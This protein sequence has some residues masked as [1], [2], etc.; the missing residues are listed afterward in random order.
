MA[1]KRKELPELHGVEVSGVA[2]EGKAIARVK[3]RETDETPI[4][5][6]IPYA[7][8]GDI[9]D[10]KIDK[11]KHSYAEAHITRI[12]EPSPIRMA[13]RCPSFGTCGGCKWQHIPYQEQLRH[14]HRIVADALERIAKVDLPEIRPT[15][16]S[17]NIW[18]YRNKM[19]YTFSNKKWR[20]W[21]DIR[22]GKE[23]AD[24]SNALGFHIPGAFDKVLHIDNCHL[25]DTKGDEIRNFIYDFA[26]SHGYSFYNIKENHGLLR[27]LMLRIASTG[28]IMVCLT[29]GEDD[30]ERIAEI[31]TAIKE[32]FPEITSLLYVVNRKL[33]DSIADQEVI[34]FSGPEYI[35]EEMEGLRFRINAK[36]FYQTNSLQAYELYK[37]AR[38]FAGLDPK[39][40]NDGKKPLVYDLYTGTG[41]IANFVARQA[42]RVI[43]IEYVEEAI[44]DAKLNASVN[45]LDNTLFYAGDMKDILTDE[46]VRRHGVPDVMIVDPPR[47]GMHEDVVK[48][49]LNASTAVIVYVSCNPA[50]QAR[51]LALL[52]ARY[53]VTA[54]QPVD[55]FPHTHHVENVVRL[56]LRQPEESSSAD[57]DSADINNCINNE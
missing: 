10:L 20:S 14:K 18:G 31:L 33:N 27:T 38:E 12:V 19:E 43:G 1:R 25:Q 5:V 41:T 54:V 21:E 28:E 52:D 39:G 23:F 34:A 4:V 24:S 53:K 30:R 48:V 26:E 13:P 35:E 6:F 45:G 42:S 49:I 46:F 7:A 50:T 2:A 3:L 56:E 47:A 37:V 15:L 8:P 22:S 36:S 9:V 51:D 16:G 40:N 17:D 57:N 44:E 29:F 32:R 55:M 11:K